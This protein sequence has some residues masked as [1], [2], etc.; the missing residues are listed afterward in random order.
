MTFFQHQFFGE[1]MNDLVHDTHQKKLALEVHNEATVAHQR[2]S[3]S[4]D[5]PV[6]QRYSIQVTKRFPDFPLHDLGLRFSPPIRPA[7][8]IG[9]ATP[10]F[11]GQDL[12]DTCHGGGRCQ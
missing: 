6:H 3:R 4:A 7:V 8:R 9:E 12:L 11:T 10:R 1:G 5:Q 2:Y